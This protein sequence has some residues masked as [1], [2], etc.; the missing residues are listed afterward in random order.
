[1]TEEDAAKVELTDDEV[2]SVLDDIA[3]PD[4]TCNEDHFRRKH[5]KLV[6]SSNLSAHKTMTHQKLALDDYQEKQRNIPT[7][8]NLHP[9]KP[10]RAHTK[11]KFNDCIANAPNHLY[12]VD[13]SWLSIANP[14]ASAL[15]KKYLARD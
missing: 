10:Y 8:L 9:P 3:H 2:D 11:G 4:Y 6:P 12:T 5:G 13:K 15:E 7:E 14:D 1:M